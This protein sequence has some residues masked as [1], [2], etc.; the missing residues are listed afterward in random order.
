MIE[1]ISKNRIDEGHMELG[2]RS[3]EIKVACGKLFQLKTSDKWYSQN[4]YFFVVG[5]IDKNRV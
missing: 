3:V 5:N 2:T 4:C 1:F